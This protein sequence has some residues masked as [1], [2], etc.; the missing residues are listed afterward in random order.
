MVTAAGD[1][2]RAMDALDILGLTAAEFEA[3]VAARL[4]RGR[5]LA[6]AVY[7]QV[8]R[9]GRFAPTDHGVG[10]H[11]AAW[12]THFRLGWP[13]LV[14]SI[15]EDDD[16][17]RATTK[18]V[19][20]SADG[21]EYECVHLPMGPGRHTL[22]CSSQVGCKMGCTFCETGRMG[23]LRQLSAAEIVGQVLHTLHVQQRPVRN[24]VFMG[25]GEALDNHAALI[26][27]LHVLTDR[28]G[29]SLAQER[30]TVCTVGHATG[31]RRLRQLGW[32][33]LGLS[34][35]LNSADPLVRERIMPITRR[36]PL[37]EIQAA[38]ID[39]PQRANFVLA[40]NICL[41][42]GINDRPQDIPLIAAFCRPLG[43]VLIHVIPYNPGSQPLT[44]SPRED[45][46]VAY[47]AAL[48]G[49]GLAVRRR[50]TKGRSV[51]AACG[52]LGQPGLRQRPAPEAPTA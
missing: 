26:Q 10:Q 4:P 20:A 23:L 1:P 16:H 31:I 17:G 29:L 24:I 46:I 34:L 51:M 27:A 42:P 15:S 7:R 45:E 52:Q 11:A 21:Q 6:R 8:F 19:L 9:A 25:M 49:A 18:S 5:G 14:R 3:A 41:M 32:K 35:S 30:L 48:R 44:R 50:I 43:R 2:A 28:A 37:E 47:I 22:C 40:V 39:Y 33:R 12:Q 13:Q 38:L 36:F